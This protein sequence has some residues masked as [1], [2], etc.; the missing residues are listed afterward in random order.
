MS[1][2]FD[3]YYIWLGI[4]KWDQPA[5]AYRLLG[6]QVFEQDR[7]VIANA[8]DRLMKHL[9]TYQIG[10]RSQ[11]SQKLLNEVA[12][13]KICLLD[14]QS[15]AKYDAELAAQSHTQKNT[16]EE[17]VAPPP[18]MIKTPVA[19]EPLVPQALDEPDEDA[20]LRSE[21][22]APA[23]TRRRATHPG[24]RKKPSLVP[25]ILLAV[26]VLIPIGGGLALYMSNEAEI[27]QREK[28]RT[29]TIAKKREQLDRKAK[30]EADR[31]AKEEADRRLKKA[32]ERNEEEKAKRKE[33]KEADR[34]AKEEAQRKAKEEAARIAKV[35]AGHTTKVTYWPN[36]QKHWEANFKD[37]KREGLVTGWYENGQ[38]K[39]ETHYKNGK[40]E[41][42]VTSWYENGKKKR[43]GHWKNGEQDGLFTRWHENGQKEAEAY[44]KDGKRDGLETT[45]YRNG[46]KKYEGHYKNGELDGLTTHWHENGQKSSETHYKNSEP[47]RLET[48]WNTNGKKESEIYYSYG[49]EVSRKE[50]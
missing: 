16:L 14:K 42:L 10:K 26:A 30:K 17:T 43:E 18:Q 48:R 31:K 47:D 45:W 15:K 29:E 44:H 13:A 3:P 1:D 19:D 34:K 33:K 6:I 5:N 27:A 38:K 25:F 37:D 22:P 39:S 12:N 7:K 20:P 40:E 28:D 46:K 21:M 9:R 23:V 50:F 49:H 11:L 32:E 4:P 35:E 36:G 41:G 2:T 8:A 24:H